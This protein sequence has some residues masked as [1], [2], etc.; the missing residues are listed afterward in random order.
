MSDVT[1]AAS[2]NAFEQLFI[3][4][5]NNFTFSKSDSAS[6]GPFSASYSVAMHLEGGT[7]TLNDDGTIEIKDVDIVWDTLKVEVCFNLP[8]WCVPSFCIVPDP[9]NGCLV[10]F[11]GFC[12][13]GPICA[14]LDLSG[15][16]SEISD[17]KASLAPMYYIDPARMP[18]WSDLDAELNGHPNKWRIFIDPEWVNVEPIDIPDTVTDLLDNAVKNAIDNAIPSWVPGV[19]KD[20]L[21]ALIGPILDLVTSVLG[22]VGSIADWLADLLDNQFNLLADIE[23]AIADYF[24]S[25]YPIFEFE[26]PYPILAAEPGLIPVKIPVRN[27]TATVD[28]HEMTVLADVGA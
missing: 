8:G 7:L 2:A 16:V 28:S 4:L 21:W 18:G 24:A 1:I 25:Q 10:G 19:V 3:A 23:T 27:L 13:G 17:V 6:F 11:P 14:P 15:L 12:L 5:R 9:W 22:I 26:D 20:I